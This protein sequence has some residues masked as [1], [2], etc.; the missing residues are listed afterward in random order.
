MDDD[1]IMHV[2]C[3]SCQ[4][5]S[6]ESAFPHTG[7]TCASCNAIEK[8]HAPSLCKQCSSCR[9]MTPA[10]TFPHTGTMCAA[11]KALTKGYNPAMC[12]KCTSCLEL[13]PFRFF[14]HFVPERM[15]GDNPNRIGVG[16]TASSWQEGSKCAVCAGK[17]KERRARRI[18]KMNVAQLERAAQTGAIDPA[19]L[20]VGIKRGDGN[21]DGPG[22]LIR[23]AMDRDARRKEEVRMGHADKR[24]AAPWNAAASVVRKELSSLASKEQYL[25]L[26]PLDTHGPALAA[27]MDMYRG[28]LS[29][30]C[31]VLVTKGKLGV[32]E[33]VR[34][35]GELHLQRYQAQQRR[36]EY[37]RDVGE[38][39]MTPDEEREYK[40][41]KH[42]FK[43]PMGSA[44]MTP[45]SEWEEHV[46]PA[47]L[48]L[49]RTEWELLSVDLRSQRYRVPP[50]LLN[51]ERR[52]CLKPVVERPPP[53]PRAPR[54]YVRAAD[55][56][57]ERAV[58]LLS[59]ARDI[60]E[61][62]RKGREFLDRTS[63]T[64]S[65]QKVHTPIDWDAEFPGTE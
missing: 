46:R 7:A 59:N 14:Q 60:R 2:W 50:M 22:A 26:H 28:V 38:S 61:R 40:E 1:E 33:H 13:K 49:L 6:L 32:K 10:S 18:P 62:A 45:H 35:Q 54:I 44:I 20:L 39:G 48:A 52:V 5:V 3:P 30:L 21:E 15:R 56:A 31:K 53:E 65:E 58:D 16:Y 63:P 47:Q 25:K 57:A 24:W 9:E 23:S 29:S 64:R 11:C 4:G 43:A 19:L 51:V 37:R 42:A 17:T 36:E 34:S 55:K 41:N 12:K 27:F 8:G